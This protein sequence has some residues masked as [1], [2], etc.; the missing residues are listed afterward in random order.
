ML[1]CELVLDAAFCIVM[2]NL[3]CSREIKCFHILNLDGSQDCC[4][5]MA[6]RLTM[7]TL[8][9]LSLTYCQLVVLVVV[10]GAST[11]GSHRLWSPWQ[12]H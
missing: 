9:F 5:G 3:L 8:R 2:Y 6:V 1:G 4:L 10:V 11:L 7:A 12:R